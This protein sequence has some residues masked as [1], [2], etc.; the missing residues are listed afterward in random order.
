MKNSGASECTSLAAIVTSFPPSFSTARDRA[1]VTPP[2]VS[3]T[4]STLPTASTNRVAR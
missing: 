3:N 1:S 4:A 2:T